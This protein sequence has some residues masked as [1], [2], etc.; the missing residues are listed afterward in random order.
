MHLHSKGQIWAPSGSK[1]KSK[2]IM[3]DHWELIRLHDI[4]FR[5][6]KNPHNLTNFGF[7]YLEPDA[8][9]FNNNLIFFLIIGNLVTS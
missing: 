3:A 2:D 9:V 6:A 8:I 5:K 4:N 7:Y 1:L